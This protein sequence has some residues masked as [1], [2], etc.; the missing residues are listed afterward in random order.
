MSS[1]SSLAPKVLVVG[2]GP[3][4]LTLA[5]SL[6]RQG[7]SVRVIDKNLAANPGQR[8]AGLFPR[9]LEVLEA[10]GLWEKV[11]KFAVAV[12][13]IAIYGLP[14]GTQVIK[15]V[16]MISPVPATPDIPHPN[17]IMLGQNHLEAMLIEA[18]VKLGGAVDRGI[19]FE[20]LQQSEDSVHVTLE[21]VVEGGLEDASYE[22][23]AGMDGGKGVVRK[24]LDLPFIGEAR[25]E[26]QV[27]FGDFYM[28]GIGSDRMHTWGDLQKNGL[29]ARPTETPRLFSLII[30][31]DIQSYINSS[32]QIEVIK[33]M[34]KEAT[35]GR[36]DIEIVDCVWHGIY[37]F[38]IR[39][40]PQFSKGRVFIGG[41]AAHV[42]SPTGGQGVNTGVQDGYNLAWKL[43]LVLHGRAPPYILNTYETERL[44]VVAEMLNLTTQMLD[45]SLVIKDRDGGVDPKTLVRGGKLNQLGVNYR[46]STIV[47]D[48][49]ESVEPVSSYGGPDGGPVRAGD[50][51]PDAS[52]LVRVG[53]DEAARLFEIFDSRLHTVVIFANRL[54][55]ELTATSILFAKYSAEVVHFVV[56]GRFPSNIQP[57]LDFPVYEDR[58]GYAD[59]AYQ[60][61]DESG[62]IFIVRPD[63]FVGARLQNIEAVQK[64]FDEI[65]C[66]RLSYSVKN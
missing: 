38:N 5:L 21:N 4:G 47:I 49:G 60:T 46:P 51:A 59:K 32:N 2:A 28:N 36:K 41:D 48:D 16:E 40:A 31:G 65:L 10:L 55:E 13:K 8:G 6:L 57:T 50:R 9:T 17:G 34:I 42:H 45:K 18:I 58:D 25:G 43:A 7:V 15:E 62:K 30:G 66:L 29:F 1:I 23:V 14:G 37:R 44:P 39:M 64:Y 11:T 20:S 54:T 52:G 53:T 22:Y 56:V 12:P 19:E 24:A 27:V 26:S 63:G 61:I 35:G 33:A 3:T